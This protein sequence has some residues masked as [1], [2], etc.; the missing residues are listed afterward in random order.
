MDE[1]LNLLLYSLGGLPTDVATIFSMG[2]IIEPTD[3]R[4]YYAINIVG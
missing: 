3:K 2:R 4:R 1:R